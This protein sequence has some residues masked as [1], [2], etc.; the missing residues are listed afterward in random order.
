MADRTAKPRP[1]LCN[2]PPPSNG[3]RVP[4]STGQ[5]SHTPTA[6]R[7][8]APVAPAALAHQTAFTSLPN[9]SSHL[10][11]PGS[12]RSADGDGRTEV[13]QPASLQLRTAGTSPEFRTAQPDYLPGHDPPVEGEEEEEDE[14]DEDADVTMDFD[15]DMGQGGSSTA[16]LASP[17]QSQ[18]KESTTKKNFVTKLWRCVSERLRC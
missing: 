2:P 4:L 18:R 17:R 5:S 6:H 12:F 8:P 7:R 1:L 3:N 9:N 16:P 10:V 11:R 13:K 15:H 14:D